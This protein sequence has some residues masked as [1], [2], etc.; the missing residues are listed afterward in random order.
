MWE[1]N[2]HVLLT[3]G[4][5]GSASRDLCSGRQSFS[6][7]CNSVTN[8]FWW[9]DTGLLHKQVSHFLVLFFW[10]RISFKNTFY[11]T[12]LP[13]LRMHVRKLQ[14]TLLVPNTFQDSEF[15]QHKEAWVMIH[16]KYHPNIFKNNNHL[17]NFPNW[18]FSVI[19]TI[20][21]QLVPMTRWTKWN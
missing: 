3:S 1:K 21:R 17:N 7:L 11:A 20:V 2:R 16:F 5:S 8:V 13:I 9:C 19:A 10:T 18:S 15:S 14:T 12:Y 6:W 4:L